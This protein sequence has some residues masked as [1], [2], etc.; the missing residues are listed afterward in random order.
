VC[1]AGRGQN[2][3][4][5][6]VTMKYHE[7]R[8]YNEIYAETG[9]PNILNGYQQEDFRKVRDYHSVVYLLRGLRISSI[10]D[11]GCGNGLLLK[12]MREQLGESIVP[13]GYDYNPLAI[14]MA[15]SQVLPEFA[16]NFSEQDVEAI[17]WPIEQDVAV[18]MHGDYAW[19]ALA[20]TSPYLLLRIRE[21]LDRR[22]VAEELKRRWVDDLERLERSR[23]LEL[24]DSKISTKR[25]SFRLYENTN[26]GEPFY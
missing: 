20:I 7:K 2:V 22:E 11:M 21:D 23:R 6:A 13:Y 9:N 14:E 26:N 16:D 3:E 12:F 8:R 4:G 1:A 17:T 10:I 18:I 25:H 24:I 19:N 15:K 5:R